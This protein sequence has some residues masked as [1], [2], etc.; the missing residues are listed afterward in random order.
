MQYRTWIRALPFVI[1][2]SCLGVMLFNCIID[3]V[4]QFRIST[5]YPI[6]YDI[7]YARHLNSGLAKNYEYHSIILGTSHTRGFRLSEVEKELVF[8]KPIK[9]C[10]NGASAFEESQLLQLALSHQNV[11]KVLY[12]LDVLSFA[13]DIERRW[14]SWPGYLYKKTLPN[15]CHYLIKT[16]TTIKSVK[17]I[18]GLYSHKEKMRFQHDRMFDYGEVDARYGKK[19]ML[20]Y[21][22]IAKKKSEYYS[23]TQMKKSFEANFLNIVQEHR[24]V[25]FSIFYPPY[26][27]RAYKGFQEQGVLGEI[28]L[29]KRYLFKTLGEM[30]NVEIYDFQI[31][32]EITHELGNFRDSTHYHPRV[33]TWILKQIKEGNYLTSD[34]NIEGYLEELLKQAGYG[35]N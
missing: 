30:E 15:M 11:S 25:N 16:D 6:Y 12:G 4:Q 5:I 14:S 20:Q 35:K 7:E 3:P 10:I 1:A 24:D 26:S 27:I 18:L 22:W 23:L 2:F 29:F 31:A 34:S 13:G 19:L 28:I 33:T 17:A 21:P 9:F 32:K 8:D